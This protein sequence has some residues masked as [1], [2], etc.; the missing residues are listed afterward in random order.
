MNVFD[1]TVFH[2]L[3]GLAG[4]Q[5][6]VDGAMI[7][8]AQFSPELFAA[9]FIAAWFV[10]PRGEFPR[11]HALV[12][13]VAGGV[14]ALL[15]NALIAHLWFRPRP[16][17][18]LAPGHF[19]QL[20]AHNADASFPSDHVSGAFGF[21]AG[22][23]GRGPRGLGLA[24]GLIAVLVAF[25]RVYVGVHWPTDVMAGAVVGIPA[26]RAAWLL[27]PALS[28]L[29]RFGLKLTRKNA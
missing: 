28:P 17:V 27:A 3:N 22:L 15:I 23:W 4:H 5:P 24:F 16:F 13:A 11:R 19:T 20:I 6:L 2:A 21:A 14:L 8:F 7:F 12:M 9:L 10:L 1:L 26:G 25:A 18:V 29:T